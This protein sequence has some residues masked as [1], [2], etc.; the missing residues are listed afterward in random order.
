LAGETASK[1]SDEPNGT[2]VKEAGKE[3][4]GEEK[5]GGYTV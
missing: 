2:S 1:T 3:H 5:T 4:S